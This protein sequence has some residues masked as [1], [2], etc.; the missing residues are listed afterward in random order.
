MKT[1]V[2]TSVCVLGY[3]DLAG[4]KLTISTKALVTVVVCVLTDYYSTWPISVMYKIRL[5]YRLVAEVKP[6]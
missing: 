2:K 4:C 3:I 6:S 1:D 5:V